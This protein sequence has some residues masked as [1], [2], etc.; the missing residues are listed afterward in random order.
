MMS[1]LINYVRKWSGGT[2]LTEVAIRTL[3]QAEGLEPAIWSSTPGD[4]YHF[5]TV[6]Q[7]KV[8]WVVQGSITFILPGHDCQQ[9]TLQPGDRLELPPH[10]P[11]LGLVGPEGLRCLEGRSTA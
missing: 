10:T 1:G 9:V 7:P 4:I 11:H 6:S 3:M 2:G 8:I 5:A